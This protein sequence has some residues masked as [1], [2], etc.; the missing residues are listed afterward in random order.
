MKT[1][2]KFS[3]NG[4]LK[5]I[6]VGVGFLVLSCSS[7]ISNSDTF[8]ES[9]ANLNAKASS[10]SI[11]KTFVKGALINGANGIDIGPDG[12]LYIAS[13]VG[14]NITVMDRNSGKIS[15]RFGPAN[16]VLG[17]DD[18]VFGPDG[19][20][21][22]T[23]LLTGY[24]G[25]MTQEG[26]ILG[27]QEIA[28]G[29]NP[30]TF[31]DDGRLFVALDFLGDSLYEL[32]PNLVD[33]PRAIIESTPEN[34]F[35]L[36]FLNSFDFGDDG[37]LYGPLFAAGLVVAINVGE[38]GDPVSTSPFT[39]G[40]AEIVA[41]EFVN[42]AAAKFGPNGL[43]YVLDQTGEVFTVDIETG[44]KTLFTT[45]PPGLDNITF[46]ADGSLYITNADEGW[47]AEILPSGEARYIS[48]G[49]MIFPQ[50]IAVLE[51]SNNQDVVFQADLFNLRVFNGA[52]GQQVDIFKGYL[53]P[54]GP[55]SLIL[56]MNLSADGDNLIISSWFS[57]G[58]QVWNPQDGVLENYPD[59]VVPID[60]VRVNGVV[61]VSDFGLGGIV[62]AADQSLIAPLS[63]ASGLATNGETL[64]AADWG[65]GDIWQIDFEGTTPIN[66]EII[67]SGLVNP[68]GLALD[69]SGRLLVVE[70][71]ASRLSRIDLSTGEVT[72]LADGLE[73]LG[74]GLGSP[75]TWSFDG[76]AVGASGDIYISGSG[77]NVLYRI[78][79]NKVE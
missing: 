30:I 31:S 22:W 34:P 53:V 46:D 50:G 32:D 76:V 19:T 28:P 54:E 51:G 18:L 52:S 75:P 55:N 23:D 20:I 61:V 42:P 9:E 71:G 38:P 13:V 1:T 26:Q 73:L 16:G 14:Q 12:N 65:T 67:A 40:T 44:T 66:S 60:A 68:E 43:L 27:Y 2:E 48:Q 74:T 64:W 47:V 36:G 5:L 70:T 11:L 6:L 35:P 29:V 77:A 69:N 78:R 7:D 58:V 8:L 37:R 72:K 57:P 49:G 3:L 39:D 33:P 10:N 63:V 79:K 45:L 21:Y 24:V 25:R 62:S 41:S 59:L 56:P 15:E 4:F 17:P